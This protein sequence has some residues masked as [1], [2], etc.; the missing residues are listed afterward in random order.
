MENNKKYYFYSTLYAI[1]LSFFS[2]SVL[3]AFLLNVGLEESKI[4]LYDA[5]INTAQVAMMALS[6][7]FSDKIRSS[8]RF[9]AFNC[10]AFIPL[11]A[12]LAAAGFGLLPANALFLPLAAVAL[13][14]YASMGINNTV[15]YRFPYEVIDIRQYG[16]ITAVC[17]MLSGALTF[18]LSSLYSFAVAGEGASRV[19]AVAF[20]LV[21]LLLLLAGITVLRMKK[22]PVPT[23]PSRGFGTAV[24]KNKKTWILLIPNFCRGIATGVI[25][26]FAVFAVSAGAIPKA[27]AASLVI[28]L[29]LANFCG[30]FLFYRLSGKAKVRKI[31]LLAACGMCVFLPLSLVFPS[32]VPVFIFY[33]LIRFFMIMVDDAIPVSITEFVPYSQIGAFTSLRMMLFTLGQA[34]SSFFL[35][36]TEGRLP[37]PVILLLVALFQLVC[38]LSYFFVARQ[39]EKEKAREGV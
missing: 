28:V 2:G 10:F 3:Q 15:V 1:S 39:S 25:S 16:K 7:F 37:Y 5:L 31:L 22:N 29:Q 32:T 21:I 11:C 38:C 9:V 4:Y 34:V 13:F 20:S 24:F 30:N 14:S 12:L 26:L 35:L 23:P 36:L 33:F 6:V 27:Y 18:G 17:G 19:S 8:G